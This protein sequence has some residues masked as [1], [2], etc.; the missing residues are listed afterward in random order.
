MMGRRPR[1][2]PARR[3]WMHAPTSESAPPAPPR[4]GDPERWESFFGGRAMRGLFAKFWGCAWHQ[5]MRCAR[6]QCLLHARLQGRRRLLRGADA[7]AV[8]SISAPGRS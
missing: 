7:P 6:L 5:L 2:Q 3:R 8:A 1:L 4:G